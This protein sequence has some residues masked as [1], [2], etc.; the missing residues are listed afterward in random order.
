MW[1]RV[2]IASWNPVI[3]DED[4]ILLKLGQLAGTNRRSHMH[5]V[6]PL[7]YISYMQ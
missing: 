1:Y 6:K 4:R 5:A 2:H 3:M 7:C